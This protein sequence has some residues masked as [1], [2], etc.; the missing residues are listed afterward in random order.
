MRPTVVVLM[1]H[2]VRAAEQT[3]FDQQMKLA[4]QLAK[5]VR[6]DCSSADLTPG[7]R[8]VMV[9][10]DDAFGSFIPN[11]LPVLIARGVPATVFA[12]TAY[13]GDV[14]LAGSANQL[15]RISVTPFSLPKN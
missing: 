6:G 2:A 11:V 15:S 13:L 14:R 5:P 10:F 12:P 4:R 7:E 9:T 8:H 3:R 1:Y